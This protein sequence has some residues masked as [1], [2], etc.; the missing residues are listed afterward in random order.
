M[1]LKTLAAHRD[2]SFL[3]DDLLLGAGNKKLAVNHEPSSI[4]QT[5]AGLVLFLGPR[6]NSASCFSGW[7]MA[8]DVGCCH[9]LHS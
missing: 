6:S 8:S 3:S 1:V 9:H 2:F 4:S 5:F 7:A